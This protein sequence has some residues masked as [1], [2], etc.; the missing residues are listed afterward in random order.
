MET[1]SRNR[2]LISIILNRNVRLLTI[3]ISQLEREEIIWSH[4]GLPRSSSLWESHRRKSWKQ[5]DISAEQSLPSPWLDQSQV[6]VWGGGG[7]G[8]GE[9]R[10]EPLLE[11][12]DLVYL[13]VRLL[14]TRPGAVVAAAL[15]RRAGEDG[16]ASLVLTLSVRIGQERLNCKYSPATTTYSSDSVLLFSSLKFHSLEFH[17]ELCHLWPS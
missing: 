16:L 15:R 8:P 14:P 17:F 4:W 10:R 3:V 1:Q 13:V 6:V 9:V 7:G 12:V 5:K 2:E 11:L